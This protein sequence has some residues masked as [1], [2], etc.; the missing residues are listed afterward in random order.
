MA[1]DILY[2]VCDGVKLSRKPDKTWLHFEAKSGQ[3]CSFCIED[4]FPSIC[5]LA[6]Q[7][8]ALDMM[9]EPVFYRCKC[10]ETVEAYKGTDPQLIICQKCKRKGQLVK[11]AF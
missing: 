10:G 7:G 8:W 9:Q 11:L 5:A 4:K 6:I 1:K 2:E 3:K